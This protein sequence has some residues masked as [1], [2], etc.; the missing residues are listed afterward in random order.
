[1]STRTATPGGT[2]RLPL[3]GSTR[4][5]LLRLVRWPAVWVTIVAWLLLNAVFG[6]VFNYVT[7]ASGENNFSNLGESRESLLASLLPTAVPDVIPQGMPMFGGALM[8]VLGAVIAGNGFVWGTW[9]TAFT[10]GPS[11]TATVLGSWAAMTVFVAGVVL[12]TV[13]SDFAMSLGVAALESQPLAWPGFGD[14]LVATGA[15][16]LV[17]LMWASAGYLLG[18]LARGPALSV[19]LGLTWALVIENLLRAVG[20]SLD[21]IATFTEFLPGTAAGSLVGQLIGVSGPDPAPGV[22]DTLSTERA[23]IT[24]AAYL[25]MLPAATL[26]L[27]RRRDVA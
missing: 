9:K 2:S 19:G 23:V 10:Q 7:Y 20:R 17:L 21:A 16:F 13:V 12:A 8:M 6:Y 14:T 25:V 4:A 11:R 3:L 26:V 5:E 15:G 18:V 22:L 24:L 27:M 1:M